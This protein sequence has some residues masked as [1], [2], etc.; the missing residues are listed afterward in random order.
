MSKSRFPDILHIRRKLQVSD[1]YRQETYTFVRCGGGIESKQ[2]YKIYRRNPF[3]ID[4]QYQG[5]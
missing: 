4:A 2:L 3:E 5:Y 1:R